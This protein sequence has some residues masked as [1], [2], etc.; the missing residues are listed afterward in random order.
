MTKGGSEQPQG[1]NGQTFQ[2]NET[3]ENYHAAVHGYTF[4]VTSSFLVCLTSKKEVI[5]ELCNCIKKF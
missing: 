3:R 5:D 4:F 2:V 1:E